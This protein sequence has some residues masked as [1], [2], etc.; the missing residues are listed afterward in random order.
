[1]DENPKAR[2]RKSNENRRGDPEETE[3]TQGKAGSVLHTISCPMKLICGGV[4]RQDA[5]WLVCLAA[6]G[7]TL[8]RSDEGGGKW[9]SSLHSSFRG[10]AQTLK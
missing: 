9:G 1:M 4:R 5:V 8:T 3:I 7:W 6:P 10:S 2:M